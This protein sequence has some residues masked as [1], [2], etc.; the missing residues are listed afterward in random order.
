MSEEPVSEAEV[1]AKNEKP[2]KKKL[3][4]KNKKQN[5]SQEEEIKLVSLAELRKKNS[6]NE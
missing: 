1:K 5:A 6:D 4:K 3:F 2:E